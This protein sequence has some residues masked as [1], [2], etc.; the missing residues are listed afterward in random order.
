MVIKNKNY[1]MQLGDTV[2]INE[3]GELINF[4]ENHQKA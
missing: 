2:C 4:T 1:M 3:N